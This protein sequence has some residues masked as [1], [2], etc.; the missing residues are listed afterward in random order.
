MMRAGNW[1]L[2]LAIVVL[3]GA[4][5]LGCAGEGTPVP[6]DT[7]GIQR[8]TSENVSSLVEDTTVSTDTPGV[9]RSSPRMNASIDSAVDSEG[10]SIHK[11]DSYEHRKLDVTLSTLTTTYEDPSEG[12][13]FR[14]E[15]SDPSDNIL[16]YSPVRVSIDVSGDPAPTLRW[17]KEN[18]V[19]T[20]E[21]ETD[22]TCIPPY[23]SYCPPQTSGN[24]AR[25]DAFFSVS[26][27]AP[28]SV[29][30]EVSAI[31]EWSS[32]ANLSPSLREEVAQLETGL[33]TGLE[34][35]PDIHVDV[36][37]LRS[38]DVRLE[39]C[40]KVE[41]DDSAKIASIESA[42]EWLEKESFRPLRLTSWV[43]TYDAPLSD[44]SVVRNYSLET[45]VPLP[46]VAGLSR[47]FVDT[48]IAEDCWGHYGGPEGPMGPAGLA[49]YSPPWLTIET[50]SSEDVILFTNKLEPNS[51]VVE[52]EEGEDGGRLAI[53]SCDAP[54]RD[55]GRFSHADTITLAGCSPGETWVKLYDGGT[56]LW[57]KKLREE[58]LAVQEPWP[59]DFVLEPVPPNPISALPEVGYF[60]TILKV[61]ESLTLRLKAATAT[62][63]PA[64]AEFAINQSGDVTDGNLTFGECPGG[65]WESVPIGNGDT[66]T[67]T[68]CSPGIVT[69]RALHPKFFE[70]PF[71]I[72]IWGEPDAYANRLERICDKSL[73]GNDSG[74]VPPPVCGE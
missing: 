33:K 34:A 20:A 14:G 16:A 71:E 53:G 65:E 62:P 46:L 54:G 26:L 32:F 21:G 11:R 73:Y 19:S 37:Y 15:P 5:F 52:V 8:T 3:A 50:G 1:Q 44:G 27:L 70:V 41:G 2:T 9:G 4:A 7:S 38:A 43:D 68:A 31:A 17:L 61:G 10:P 25:I 35:E 45:H 59:F 69:G 18:G 51:I 74:A 55:R 6:T 63:A 57:R 58:R 24:E 28:L 23:Y 22:G 12:P 60:S 67:V 40:W 36:A 30:P 13:S 42:I 72:F 48:F 47:K 29:R 49:V 66:V 39:I 64:G 56:F